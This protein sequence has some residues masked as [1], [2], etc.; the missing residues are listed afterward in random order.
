MLWKCY[1]LQKKTLNMTIG[2]NHTSCILH[3]SSCL[4]FLSVLNSFMTSVY[5]FQFEMTHVE[6][7]QVHLIKEDTNTSY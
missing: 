2:N 3:R 4:A 5:D 1:I 7:T 6:S